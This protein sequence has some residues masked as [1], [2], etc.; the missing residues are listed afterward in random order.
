MFA[1]NFMKKFPVIK[2]ADV[3]ARGTSRP[4]QPIP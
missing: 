4:I 2:Y 3:T 1:R